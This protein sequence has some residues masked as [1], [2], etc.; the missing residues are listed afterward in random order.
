MAQKVDHFQS[1]GALWCDLMHDSPMWPIHGEYQCR[2]CG[3]HYGVPWAEQR[4]LPI[5]HATATHVQSVTAPCASLAM[6]ILLS[7]SLA[8]PGRASAPPIVDSTDGASLAFAR[9]TAGLAEINPWRLETV[10]I[11]ASL[12]R[13]EKTGRMR[14][15]RRLLP[16][17]KPEY[18]VLE[19]TGDA[20]VKQQVIVRY[21]LA[22]IRSAAIPA[23]SVAVTPANYRFRYKGAVQTG[24]SV[25]YV[26]LVTPRK[27][28]DGLIKGELWLDGT[29]GA[30]VRQSGYLVKRPAIFVKRIDI[31]RETTLCDGIAATRVTQLS[32]DTRLVGRA[33]LTILERPYAGSS[34]AM[35]SNID[36]R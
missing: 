17:G 23:S 3:R 12:P 30:D 32:V 8:V 19:I 5:R 29:T 24:E 16:F 35:G 21:L 7:L 11:E 36:E 26:F 2:T 4:L 25:A 13:L 15:I 27:K 20:T 34:E 28:R 22:D 14:A 6:I 9:Y 18:Q 1:L 10:E 31:T 33:E